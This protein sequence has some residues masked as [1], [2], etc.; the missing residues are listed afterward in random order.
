MNLTQ[1]EAKCNFWNK[2]Q[3]LSGSVIPSEIGPDLN[4]NGTPGTHSFA[5]LKFDNGLKSTGNHPAPA[6]DFRCSASWF[7]E[8]KFVMEQWF[9][10]DHNVTN[11]ATAGS[12]A[13]HTFFGWYQSASFWGY[14]RIS[15][16]NTS[17]FIVIN[18]TGYSFNSTSA[19]LTW[20]ANTSHHIEVAFDAD[21]ID[22]G[23]IT[24][25]MLLDG[26]QFFTST[27]TPGA[28]VHSGGTFWMSSASSDGNPVYLFEGTQDNPKFYTD[29][30]ITQDM[31]D[32]IASN[33]DNEG[34]GTIA[35][36]EDK[37]QELNLSWTEFKALE[38]ASS[39]TIYFEEKEADPRKVEAWIIS[40][41]NN[42]IYRTTISGPIDIADFED[43][44]ETGATET[45]KDNAI[46]LVI[47]A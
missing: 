13:Y 38:T 24:C 6:E 29:T 41:S 39:A 18:G 30:I 22:E 28:G 16:V 19:T 26:V 11:G 33:K 27:T 4:Q 14:F 17:L 23:S 43:N 12:G 37:V 7:N 35:Q 46:A 40:S 32:L 2:L 1:L 10:T 47:G 20:L 21:G 25:K 5:P 36:K 34:F 45:S 3:G 9:K 8:R 31:I 15:T 44:Y 42:I